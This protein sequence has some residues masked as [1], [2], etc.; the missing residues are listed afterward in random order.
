MGGFRRTATRDAAPSPRIPAQ[1]ILPNRRA[2]PA[3]FPALI[4]YRE[5]GSASPLLRDRDE[6]DRAVRTSMDARMAACRAG[7]ADLP[8]GLPSVD[9]RPARAGRGAGEDHPAE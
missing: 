1:P 9:P 5:P 6:P 8:V 4:G 3:P 2:E 7:V